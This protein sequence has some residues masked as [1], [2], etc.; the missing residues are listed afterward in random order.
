MGSLKIL[1]IVI[2]NTSELDYSIPLLVEFKRRHAD[3]QVNVLYCAA[4]KRKILRQS[5]YYSRMLAQ[6]GIH[7]LDFG[8]FLKRSFSTLEKFWRL[9][10]SKSYSDRVPLK[11]MLYRSDR[12]FWAHGLALIP[13]L[14]R[15]GCERFW[16]WIEW[17]ALRLVAMDKILA[18]LD[19][20][21]I[22]LGNR[23]ITNF[24]GRDHFFNYFYDKKKPVVLLPHGVHEVH[25]T[26]EFIPF[27]ER[28]EAMADFCD[29]WCSLRF[30]TP[31]LNFPGREHLFASIGYPGLDSSWIESVMKR[32][33]QVERG[34]IKGLFVIRKFLP[35]G[36]KKPDNYDPFTLEYETMAHYTDLLASALEGIGRPVDIIIKPHPSNNYP[37]LEEILS[38]SKLASWQISHEPMYALLPEIDFAVSLFSTSLLI[39]AMA[40]IPVVV[41]NSELMQYVHNR[42]DRLRDLYTGLQFYVENVSHMQSAIE[43]ALASRNGRASETEVD[44]ANPDIQHLKFY[45]PDGATETAMKR[46]DYLLSKET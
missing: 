3:A 15:G 41:L 32:P 8:N 11:E 45:Y 6:N 22:L 26:K 43:K 30:E 18:T 38:S 2:K 27:D 37:M 13:K 44:G 1:Q 29:F 5:T 9:C 35:R 16:S 31:W 19:P 42:W 17:H 33:H 20:D 21:L 36:C 24:R 40:G 14:F 23:T 7:E 28:G 4:D 46:L 25:P 12:L 39:P 10:F 34:R